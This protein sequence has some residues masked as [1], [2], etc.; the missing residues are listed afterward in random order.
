MTSLWPTYLRLDINPAG[1]S[2]IDIQ[3]WI[4]RNH[5]P[6]ARIKCACGTD[7]RYFDDL[8]GSLRNCGGVSPRKVSAGLIPSRLDSTGLQGGGLEEVTKRDLFSYRSA[9]TCSAWHFLST[10]SRSYRHLDRV[11]QT[12]SSALWHK[13]L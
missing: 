3:R 5:A 7:K 10:V 13:T 1:I 9:W 8:L 6:V 2:T 4:Y 11:G 12:A